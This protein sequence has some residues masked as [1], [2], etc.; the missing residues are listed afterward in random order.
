MATLGAQKILSLTGEEKGG[1]APGGGSGGGGKKGTVVEAVSPETV[2]FQDGVT[3]LGQTKARQSITVTS[4]N[5]ELIT[6]VLFRSGQPVREGQVLVELDAREQDADI[7]Q[8]QAAAEQATREAQ[9]WHALADKGIAPRATAEQF[10]A[11]ADRAD[12]V[13]AASRAR[14]LDRVIRAPFSGIVGLS[15]AAPGQL[16]APGTPI[17]S[18]DDLS[19]IRVDFDVPERYVGLVKVG[20]PV[21]AQIAA[22]E[23][24]AVQGKVAVLDSRL[25]PATRALKARAEFANPGG[26][27]RPGMTVRVLLVQAERSVM[28]VPEAAILFEGDLAS[29][30]RIEASDKGQAV[31]KVPIVTGLRQKGLVEVV[32]GLSATDKIVAAGTNRLRPGETVKLAGPDKEGASKAV[33]SNSAKAGAGA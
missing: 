28:A 25:D 33:G 21:V 19:V 31:K 23:S 16:I 14:K 6:R 9:R 24:G 1:P 22:A 20:T 15:D 4:S 30:Y 27:V 11:S 7:L 8:A 3:V 18:L 5:A 17:V 12:A 13:L 10:K 29:V 32:S 2:L 26:T